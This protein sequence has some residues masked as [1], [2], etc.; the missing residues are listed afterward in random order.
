MN[1]RIDSWL[2]L[3]DVEQFGEPGR[4]AAYIVAG[5]RLALIETGT[6][7]AA[8]ILRRVL[9]G[10][11]VAFI[12][13]SHVHLDH[14][15]SAG[16]IAADHPEATIVASPRSI[17]HLI[18]PTGLINGVREASPELSPLYGEPIPIA[19]DRL[20]AASDSEVFNLGGGIEIEAVNSP[21]HAPHHFSF[22]ER[23]HGYL[24]TGDAL[25]NHGV[26]A[27]LPLTVPPR[28][29]IER[30]LATL[31]RFRRLR[32]TRIAF[33]HFGL[34]K[35]DPLRIIAA[36]G[37]RL[38]S[39]FERIEK[40][41]SAGLSEGEIVARILAEPEYRDLSRIDRASVSMCV[42]GALATIEGR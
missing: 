8:P 42:R 32:P 12:F 38:A 14:A 11:E 23:S 15:G 39:W 9:H 28:F 27:D 7:R 21:G 17:P 18:D 31:E 13:V 22:F 3:I 34:S 35:D 19:K 25:G 30:A 20:H 16:Y 10:R 2:E 5:E 1:I 26:P 40:E 36:H 41:R 24:F 29:D 6:A 33:T 37:K 4:G